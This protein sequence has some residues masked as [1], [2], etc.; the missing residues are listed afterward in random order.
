MREN[1]IE[2]S[3]FLIISCVIICMLSYDPAMSLSSKISGKGT[4]RRRIPYILSSRS[5]INWL[6]S[7]Y[8][9]TDLS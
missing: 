4:L 7:D 1:I 9:I 8:D 5:S 2:T 6:R 3:G